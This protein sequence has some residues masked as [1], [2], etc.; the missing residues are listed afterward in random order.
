ML[1][2]CVITGVGAR[3]W[4]WGLWNCIFIR[5]SVLEHV[6]LINVVE[7]GNMSCGVGEPV[8]WFT[9]HR[10]DL[11]VWFTHHKT[12]H[13]SLL[14]RQTRSSLVPSPQELA[15]FTHHKTY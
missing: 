11:V 2:V 14:T 8:A 6:F 9:H 7:G 3:G 10:M 12:Y 4:W 1:T 15:W 5:M 13:G